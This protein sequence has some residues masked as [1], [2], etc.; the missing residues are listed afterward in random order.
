MVKSEIVNN[1]IDCLTEKYV[2]RWGFR[3]LIIALKQ[4]S[5]LLSDF[6]V[7]CMTVWDKCS[8]DS[9]IC[10]EWQSTWRTQTNCRNRF[11]SCVKSRDISY[12]ESISKSGVNESIKRIDSSLKLT[13][14]WIRCWLRF[15][16]I[17][18][19]LETK[20]IVFMSVMSY[21]SGLY[22]CELC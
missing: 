10:C 1:S 3:C 7:K 12:N 4:W 16:S 19:Y 21:R 2:F 6:V 22:Y 8:I 11:D 15:D 13:I 20:S 18:S 9:Q 5:E 17:D 14:D